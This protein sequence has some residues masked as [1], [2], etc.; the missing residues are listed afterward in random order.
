VGLRYNYFSPFTEVH[1]SEDPFDYASCGGYC[2]IG[3]AFYFPN[4]GSFDPR[5]GVAWSPSALSG[6]TVFRAGFG[7]YHGEDQL[8][9]EDSPVVNTE[10]ST[11]L[12]SGVQ[13]NGSTVVYSYPVS[14]SLT[15]TTGL[16]LTPRSMAR[17]HPDSYVEQW[18]ASIQRA[19]PGQSVLTVTYL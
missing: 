3:A 4:Y 16:A 6:T 5:V 8:G 19:L 1:N 9:D 2:G 7:M 12:T 10:P 15:P 18:T 13:S 11:L 17:H 14:P